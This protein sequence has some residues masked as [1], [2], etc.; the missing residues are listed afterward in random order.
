[1]QMNRRCVQL[2]KTYKLVSSMS[3]KVREE[4]LKIVVATLLLLIENVLLVNVKVCHAQIRNTLTHKFRSETLKHSAS[5]NAS[6]L[7]CTVFVNK[8]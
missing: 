2:V 6:L 8:H 7:R 5:L 4:M 3:S 1:M